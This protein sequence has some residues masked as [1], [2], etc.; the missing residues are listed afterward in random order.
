[1]I[2]RL[3]GV[4]KDDVNP[5]FQLAEGRQSVDYLKVPEDL[6]PFTDESLL[7]PVDS[8]TQEEV[9]GP[10]DSM[11]QDATESGIPKVNQVDLQRI[12][13]DRKEVFWVS[14]SSGP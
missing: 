6:D 5:I 12:V 2:D 8:N 13:Y 3:N 14:F 10:I 1:M 4:R 11:L 7:D 9:E